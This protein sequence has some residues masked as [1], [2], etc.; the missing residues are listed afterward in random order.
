[1]NNREGAEDLMNKSVSD[2]E[3]LIDNFFNTPESDA[4]DRRDQERISRIAKPESILDFS[5]FFHMRQAQG[6]PVSVF[7]V[8]GLDWAMDSGREFRPRLVT[9]EMQNGSCGG[10]RSR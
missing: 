9:G 7:R 6:L 10:R 4:F 3:T 8:G 1:M 2:L 5:V